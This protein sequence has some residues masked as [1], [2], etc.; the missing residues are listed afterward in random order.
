MQLTKAEFFIIAYVWSNCHFSSY[1]V[2]L[3][4]DG[5]V[6]SLP[7]FFDSPSS[8]HYVHFLTVSSGRKRGELLVT[9]QHPFFHLA[10]KWCLNC[11]LQQRSWWPAIDRSC[12]PVWWPSQSCPSLGFLW[13]LASCETGRHQG[14]TYF[15]LCSD[16]GATPFWASL[17]LVTHPSNLW[18]GTLHG[19]HQA[20][21]PF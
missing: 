10:F 13:S 19:L 14:L 5:W 12:H 7:G 1:F 15:S 16:V 3:N 11:S 21:W 8:D 17:E 9:W 4:D 6:N 20:I 2:S 18:D